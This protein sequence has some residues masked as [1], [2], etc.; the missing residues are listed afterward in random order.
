MKFWV[1]EIIVLEKNSKENLI[2]FVEYLLL[3]TAQD[4]Q[5]DPIIHLD[6]A[7]LIHDVQ[8]YLHSL[9]GC[10]GTER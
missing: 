6:L 7:S 5:T 1:R 4:V 3:S 8:G 10:R 9:T 2:F